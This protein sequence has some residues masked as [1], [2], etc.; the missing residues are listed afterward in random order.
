MPS[1]EVKLATLAAANTTLQ[2]DL[3]NPLRWYDLQLVPGAIQPSNPPN[4]I[5][6]SCVRVR[7]I[8]TMR[9]YIQGNGVP[10]SGTNLSLLSTPRF[11]IDVLDCCAEIARTVANDVINFLA[12][13]CLS[14]QDQFAS[15]ITTPTQ[16]PSFLLSQRSGMD[17][18]VSSQ[19][20]YVQTLDVRIYNLETF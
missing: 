12:T 11:Q 3:G 19:P 14:S 8:S 15:P 2:T 18:E 5:G 10:T 7:R 1:A 4:Q 13:V 16:F 6:A 9:R 20:V 17:Y